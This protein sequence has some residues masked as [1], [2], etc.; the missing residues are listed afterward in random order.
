MVSQK[1]NKHFEYKQHK[2]ETI[3]RYKNIKSADINCVKAS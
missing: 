2:I 1:K 3:K